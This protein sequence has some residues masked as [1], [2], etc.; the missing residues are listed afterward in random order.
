MNKIIVTS[1]SGYIDIDVLSC[2]VAYTELLNL[3]NKNAELVLM[4]K[5]NETISKTMKTWSFSFNKNIKKTGKEEFVIVDVSNPKYFSDFVGHSKII[6]IFDHRLGFENFWFE[7]LGKNS[8]IEVIGTCATLIWEEFEKQNLSHKISK[9]SAN[10]L[11]TTIFS[12]TLNFQSKI[13]TSRDKIAFKK[14]KKYI[15]LPEDWIDIYYNEIDNG[16]M[17]NP[18]E[19]I[20][21]DKKTIEIKGRKY[22]I[23]QL[24]LWKSKLLLEDNGFLKTIK[25]ILPNNNNLWLLTVPTLFEKATYFYTT[26][27]E[28]QL[29]LSKHFEVIFNN[30]LAKLPYAILRKEIMHKLQES[31]KK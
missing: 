19:A 13:T 31:E 8:H 7:M 26:S 5:M 17:K 16:I 12:H 2:G 21:N 10:L 11:Y 27:I 29:I 15:D 23:G 30:N 3:Q 18:I 24:E 22:S 9:L 1:G 14:L 25:N 28:M 20:M 6:E 4:G